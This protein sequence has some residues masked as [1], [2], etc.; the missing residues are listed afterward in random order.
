MIGKRLYWKLYLPALQL[1]GVSLH[2]VSC[3]PALK[4]LPGFG[5]EDSMPASWNLPETAG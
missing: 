5:F 2:Q 1:Q 4:S 3:C